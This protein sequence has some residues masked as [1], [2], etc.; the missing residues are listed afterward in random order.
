ME[1]ILRSWHAILMGRRPAMSIE[2]TRECPLSCP[3]CY[4]YSEN[5]LGNGLGLRDLT[6]FKGD[7]LVERVLQLVREDRPLHLSIVGG[8]PLVRYRELNRL[9]PILSGMGIHTQVVTSAVRPIP[10]EW[11]SIPRLDI[12]VSIDGPQPQHDARRKPAT[13]DRI[14]RHIEGH[15]VTVHCTVTRQFAREEGGLEAFVRFW[16]DVA[17]VKRI[18][19][20]LYTPQV[21]ELSMERLTGADR[22]R[23]VAELRRLAS[24]YPKIGT[25]RALLAAM[26][27][28]PASPDGCI[29]AKTTR[30]VSAD[31][32]RTVEPCQFGGRPDCE[33][34]G[35]MA[36]A[37]LTALGRHRL[38]GGIAVGTLFD[39]S[40]RIGTQ[41]QRLRDAV[42][43]RLPEKGPLPQKAPE[44]GKA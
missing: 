43:G 39:W 15:Q 19:F 10:P 25:G 11:T 31:L 32:E 40:F 24:R 16:S 27:T 5:H 23:V 17:A 9:L 36:S 6:D 35:C 21:G 8:E 7:A 13:Y 18:W 37:G 2:I 4:A 42:R 34:C 22:E 3:G 26:L 33:N 12:S 28:P 30:C 14:L 44:T 20:S 1:G 41:T 38:P 29:F